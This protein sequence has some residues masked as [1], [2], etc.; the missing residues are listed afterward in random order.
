MHY[1]I[2][3][4]SPYSACSSTAEHRYDHPLKP[5]QLK[6]GKEDCIALCNRQSKHKDQGLVLWPASEHTC[7]SA[8]LASETDGWLRDG[9]VDGRILGTVQHICQ[10][11]LLVDIKQ[12][13]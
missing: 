13:G 8:Q 6:S 5:H 12:A 4:F 10:E 9:Q 2:I 3:H 7:C 11:T 1:V